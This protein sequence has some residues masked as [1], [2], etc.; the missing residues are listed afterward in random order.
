MFLGT[1]FYG[2]GM[3]HI[4]PQLDQR[5]G[6]IPIQHGYDVI[7]G[8]ELWSFSTFPKKGEVGYDTWRPGDELNRTG[9][10]V[11]AFA[12]TV[13]EKNGLLYFPVSGPGANLL[14]R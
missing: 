12:L 11:W 1:N 9:N 13:D 7:T 4:G 6:Q 8:K 10:N 5:G 3:T 14:R 2:P